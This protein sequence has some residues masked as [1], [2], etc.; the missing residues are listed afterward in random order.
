M[1]ESIQHPFK[2]GVKKK[3]TKKH[4]PLIWECMLGTVFARDP[5]TDIVKYFDYDYVGAHAW[6]KVKD[7]IDL[8]VDKTPCVGYRYTD[9]HGMTI[10]LAKGR[11]ALWGVFKSA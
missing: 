7:C 3:I 6:A 2:G 10:P 1:S 5:E 11:A 4:C 9:T 8:R